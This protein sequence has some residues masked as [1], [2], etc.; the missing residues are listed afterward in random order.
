MWEY[1]RRG[2]RGYVRVRRRDFGAPALNL[3]KFRPSVTKPYA[4]QTEE[5]R[6]VCAA[7]LRAYIAREKARPTMYNIRD[8]LVGHLWLDVR[9]EL[10]ITGGAREK[11]FL[12][13]QVVRA[14][15]NFYAVAAKG[16]Y[17]LGPDTELMTLKTLRRLAVERDIT[18]DTPAGVCRYRLM[19]RD[20]RE[21]EAESLALSE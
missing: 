15:R 12:V 6:A 7:E 18:L 2:R 16:G 9:E 17:L 14:G 10:R 20:G 21:K 3:R 5:E 13:G 11:H 8:W 1:V 19:D 4:E